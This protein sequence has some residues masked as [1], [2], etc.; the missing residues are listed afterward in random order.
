MKQF[1]IDP[2]N[3]YYFDLPG[4][5]YNVKMNG[6]TLQSQNKADIFTR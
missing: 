5:S 2:L 6:V 4:V 1:L 3:I